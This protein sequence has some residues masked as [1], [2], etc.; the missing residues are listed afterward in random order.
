M[1]DHGINVGLGTDGA[2]S[3][4]RLD[5]LNEMRLAALLAKGASGEA[6][7]LR[8]HAALHMAT[9]AGAKAL[10]LER[11]IG[12]LVPGKRADIT[13]IDLGALELSPCYNVASHLVYV[14][15]REHVAQVWVDGEL[16]VADGKL[17]NIDERELRQKAMYWKDKALA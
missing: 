3:N 10:G 8:A 15:G 5:L 16:L 6:T 17:L 13:A 9:L 4:N 7:A 11:R 1:L 12:S 2:A 14:A